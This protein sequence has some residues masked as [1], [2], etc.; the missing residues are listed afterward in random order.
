MLNVRCE[1]NETQKKYGIETESLINEA[2]DLRQY[3]K[4]EEALNILMPLQKKYKSDS[5]ITGTI[6]TFFYELNDYKS[7]LK[8]FKK[9]TILNPASE[10]ASLGLFHSLIE[11][12]N[13]DKAIDELKRYSN[14][15]KIKLYKI[16]IKELKNNLSDY[17]SKQQTIL[18]QIFEN[19]VN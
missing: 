12:N 1:M 16:T 18:K 11:M 5:R 14:N 8:Y 3:K 17:N 13:F 10:L 7:S 9:T 15:N 19:I 2:F 4:Y 6:A